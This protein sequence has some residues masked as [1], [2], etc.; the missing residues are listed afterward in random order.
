MSMLRSLSFGSYLREVRQ[1]LRGVQWPTRAAT[2]RFT[3]LVVVV[4]LGVAMVTGA[5]DAV[6][7]F[8][9]QRFLLR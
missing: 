7:A 2:V 9:V 5:L 8:L 1:E 3:L 6:L 4:S